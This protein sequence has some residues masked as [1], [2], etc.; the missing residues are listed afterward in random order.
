MKI[1]M[2]PELIE[3]AVR[4]FQTAKKGIILTGQGLSRQELRALE[5][6]G[7]VRMQ[8]TRLGNRKGTGQVHNAW[9]INPSFGRVD[10]D[11]TQVLKR[12]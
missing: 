5:R 3:K 9:H 2:T 8:P 12:G 6:E 7:T 10:G 4:I 11:K 1:K